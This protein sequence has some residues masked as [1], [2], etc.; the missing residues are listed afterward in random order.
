ML[1]K[2]SAVRMYK[3]MTL[4]CKEDENTEKCCELRLTLRET[5][6]GCRLNG[7]LNEAV[8]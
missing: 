1:G 8:L 2:C 3:E 4:E 6:S 7:M 5:K